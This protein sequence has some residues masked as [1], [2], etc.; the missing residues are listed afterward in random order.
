MTLI[1][2]YRPKVVITELDAPG[3]SPTGTPVDVSRDF[4]DHALEPSV[5]TSTVKTFLGSYTIAGDVEESASIT[6]AVHTDTETDWSPFVGKPIQ[7]QLWDREDADRHRIFES[8]LPA[9]PS[10]YG[11]TTTGEARQPSMDLPVLSPIAWA[12]GAYTPPA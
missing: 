9:D 12:A 7:I 2:P 6:L 10:L 1:K 11:T 8:E 3:G 5:P 4:I